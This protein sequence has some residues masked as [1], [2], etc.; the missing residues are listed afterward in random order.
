MENKATLFIV[1][2]IC[3][4][5][6]VGIALPYPVLAPL[7]LT[8]SNPIN[9]YLGLD[10]YLLL[11]ITL[12]AYPLG[13]FVG[14]QVLGSW[15]DKVGRRPVLLW[16]LAG[17][18]LTN[19]ISAWAIC[20]ENFILFLISRLLSG[21]L[22]GNISVARAV[23]TDIQTKTSKTAAFSYVIAAGQAGWILGPLIGG[24]TAPYGYNMPFILAA[25]M[26]LAAFIFV[27]LKFKETNL[28]AHKTAT[29]E[30]KPTL[31]FTK[32][33]NFSRLI[34]IQFLFS[35]SISIFIE[36]Y[37][38]YLVA[39]WNSTPETLANAN[40]ICTAVM[41]FS[42]VYLL[43]ILDKKYKKNII[44]F[45]GIFL[46]GIMLI[47]FTMPSTEFGAIAIL[48]VLGGVIGLYTGT[49]ASWFSE[50]FHYL[51]Q[52]KLM[53]MLLS[54]FCLANFIVALLGSML[55]S[56]NISY[57]IWVGGILAMVSSIAFLFLSKKESDYHQTVVA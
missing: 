31:S 14:S 22:E 54:S 23:I 26:N 11:G 35:I 20:D 39:N 48:A 46:S 5:A 4:I 53:G 9:L 32:D 33:I 36:F 38:V 21:I 52:G 19:V 51:P 30:N 34:F 37:P 24:Y 45:S 56:I 7:F 3:F 49:Q 40:I 16:T 13:L 2:I 15:S 28:N 12:S 25:I 10:P 44:L 6:N 57:L 18:T 17:G 55:A 42:G 27:F 8:S 1:I 41:I 47:A 29:I 43:K 50:K